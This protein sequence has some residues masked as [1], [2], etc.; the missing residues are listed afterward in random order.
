MFSPIILH[1]A[2]GYMAESSASSN[3]TAGMDTWTYDENHDDVRRMVISHGMVN[4]TASMYRDA[5]G[6]Q[7]SQLPPYYGLCYAIT[8][9][10]IQS[11]FS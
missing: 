7:Y 8:Y 6:R 5:L 3:S 10:N 9:M 11:K 4:K 1:A 2:S